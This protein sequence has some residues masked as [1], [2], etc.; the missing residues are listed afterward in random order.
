M[1]IN[2]NRQKRDHN[3]LLCFA[4]WLCLLVFGDDCWLLAS[5]LPNV[6]VFS[7]DFSV[8]G[9]HTSETMNLRSVCYTLLRFVRVI[10]SPAH[11]IMVSIT[12]FYDV[13]LFIHDTS[14]HT[15]TIFLCL[16]LVFDDMQWCNSTALDAVHAILSDTRGSCI[17]L[18]LTKD[19][20]PTAGCIAL[21]KKD[22]MVMLIS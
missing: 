5:V 18:H 15:K 4:A 11:P 12:V 8:E 20:K 10:S 16:Q 7:S 19:Y 6:S 21:N 3:H 9:K 22:F 1:I 14:P 13:K 2:E 17:F